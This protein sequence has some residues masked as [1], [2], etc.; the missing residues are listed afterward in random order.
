MKKIL[1]TGANGFIGTHVKK[2]LKKR[3]YGIIVYDRHIPE[4]FDE[5]FWLGDVR[6][7]NSLS[8][9]IALSDGAINL[10]GILGTSETVDNPF[11]SAETNLMGGL[12][13]LEACRQHKKR[14]VQITVGNH[15]MNNT[16]SITRSA[17]E[18]FALMYNKEHGT[19]VAI[20]RGLSVYGEHQKHKPVRKIAPNFI[21]K[22]LRG[23]AITVF[24]SGNNI[25]DQIYVGDIAYILVEALLNEN[26]KF[27]KIYEAG[28][29]VKTSVNDIANL[30][31]RLTDNQAGTEHIEMRAG[32]IDESIV[33]GNPETLKEL[34]PND[35]KFTD[36]ETGYRKTIAWYK[37]NYTW[38]KD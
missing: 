18:R 2:E 28:T 1:I 5:D 9:A 15:Y 32:E 17:I 36:L 25:Q 21:C 37:E 13:F 16:Y 23:E 38:Q 31:N 24:G 29:G 30:V 19:K 14:G 33:L 27:D 10:A 4:K 20:V 26:T 7:R 8:E 11:P 35:F 3:G 12:N 22:A 34:L 6:D